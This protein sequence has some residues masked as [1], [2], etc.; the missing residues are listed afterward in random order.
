MRSEES[1][2]AESE[3]FGGKLQTAR[4]EF[5][6]S[7]AL[8]GFKQDRNLANSYFFPTQYQSLNVSLLKLYDS[9]DRQSQTDYL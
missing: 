6:M 9:Y 3:I 5:N 4:R 7:S 2:R 8:H 1:K